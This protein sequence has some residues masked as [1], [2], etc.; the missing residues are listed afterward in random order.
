MTKWFSNVLCIWSEMKWKSPSYASSSVAWLVSHDS[1]ILI[2]SCDGLML[3]SLLDIFLPQ[4]LDAFLIVG[5]SLHIYFSS[6]VK[7]LS[8]TVLTKSSISMFLSY[9]SWEQSIGSW[10]LIFRMSLLI[11]IHWWY[12]I[13]EVLEKIKELLE[14]ALLERADLPLIILLS[15]SISMLILNY[16]WMSSTSWWEKKIL[17]YYFSYGCYHTR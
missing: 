16:C 9:D 13:E 17:I 15:T 6:F 11:S 3:E 14:P 12:G 10:Q 1:W 7:D 2:I 4:G 5:V 8:V